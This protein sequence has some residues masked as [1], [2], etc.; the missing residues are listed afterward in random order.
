MPQQVSV[1]QGEICTWSDGRKA[2]N[3][4]PFDQL[5]LVS[6]QTAMVCVQSAETGWNSE[7]LDH[8]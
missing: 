4:K 8:V 2:R 5:K 7:N 6:F 1:A 3:I